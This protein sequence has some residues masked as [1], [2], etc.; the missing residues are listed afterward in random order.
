MRGASTRLVLRDAGRPR[1][2]AHLD[3][4]RYLT[5][6]TARERLLVLEGDGP[7]LDVGCGP[8]R[9][10]QA[11][12]LAGRPALGIDLSETSIALARARRLPVARL[13]VFEPVPDEG[14]WGTVLLM[15]GNIGIGGDPA[16]LLVRCAEIVRPGG[17]V[18]IETHRRAR[19]DRRFAAELVG[20]DL[21]ASLPFPWAEVGATGLRRHASGAGL[22]PVTRRRLGRRRVEIY[23]RG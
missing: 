20:D 22:V 6:P 7:V 15:D 11:A 1:R 2:R 18:V 13:S 21:I 12:L 9:M 4:A 17:H 14:E 8:G 3:V 23:R 19:R 16:R 10:V 5:A